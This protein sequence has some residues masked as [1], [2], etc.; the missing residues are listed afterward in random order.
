ML[1][2]TIEVLKQLMV[3]LISTPPYHRGNVGLICQSQ[4]ISLPSWT[5][6]M[7][8]PPVQSLYLRREVLF[9]VERE[10]GTNYIFIVFFSS[11]CFAGRLGGG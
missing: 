3:S 4:I 11:V 10:R 1:F 2:L 5:L 7:N 6:L 9:P 8:V